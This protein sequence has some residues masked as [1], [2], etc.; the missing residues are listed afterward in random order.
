MKVHYV[1]AQQTRFPYGKKK[2][3]GPFESGLEALKRVPAL[4]PRYPD[5]SVRPVSVTVTMKEG[6][7]LLGGPQ[8]EEGT[9]N[10]A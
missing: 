8:I 4:R 9:T 6:A 3:A 7:R 1:E 2:I 10:A 5:C